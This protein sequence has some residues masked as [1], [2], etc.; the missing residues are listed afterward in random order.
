MLPNARMT[1]SDLGTSAVVPLHQFG[2]S[3][4]ER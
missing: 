4:Q 1:K 3:P 2:V